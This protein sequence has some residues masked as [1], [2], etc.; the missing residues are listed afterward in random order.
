M[1]ASL[2]HIVKP[3]II[4]QSKSILCIWWQMFEPLGEGPPLSARGLDSLFINV[5]TMLVRI[6]HFW[7]QLI[8]NLDIIM[9]RCPIIR[10]TFDRFWFLYDGVYGSSFWFQGIILI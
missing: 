10:D 1:M 9:L 6:I 7:L 8:E 5:I 2:S 4:E 3:L